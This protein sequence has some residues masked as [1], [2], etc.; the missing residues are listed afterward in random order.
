MGDRIIVAIFKGDQYIISLYDH[1]GG[2][3]LKNGELLM[4]LDKMLSDL[5]KKANDISNFITMFIHWYRE[6]RG[7]SYDDPYTIYLDTIPALPDY[8]VLVYDYAKGRLYTMDIDK[9][10]EV[11]RK[12]YGK[13]WC[14]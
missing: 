4:E 7:H 10:Y 12:T 3:I 11:A 13:S 2:Y 5:R 6:W 9:F 8:E 14:E 1:W